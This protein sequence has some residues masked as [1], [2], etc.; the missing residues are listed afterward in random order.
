MDN[1]DD[2]KRTCPECKCTHS[3]IDF[4][5]THDRYGIPWKKVCDGCYEKVSDQI[6]DYVFDA[7][8]AGESLEEEDY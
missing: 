5:W 2:D 8:D 3:A 6:A 7:A 1:D 4:R